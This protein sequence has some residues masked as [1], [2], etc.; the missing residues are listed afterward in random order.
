MRTQVCFWHHWGLKTCPQELTLTLW[1]VQRPWHHLEPLSLI[2]PI[3]IQQFIST[4]KLNSTKDV[5]GVLIYRKTYWHYHSGVFVFWWLIINVTS[6]VNDS[7]RLEQTRHRKH[8]TLE[9]VLLYWKP[10]LLWFGLMLQILT[11]VL[12]FSTAAWPR[13]RYCLCI[14]MQTLMDISDFMFLYKMTAKDK[15]VIVGPLELSSHS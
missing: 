10:A 13:L 12:I 7:L 3:T 14:H 5:P 4:K 2:L 8:V 11:A 1:F 15:L 9:V 6:A